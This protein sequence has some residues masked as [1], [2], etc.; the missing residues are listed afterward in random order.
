MRSSPQR[1]RSAAE[2]GGLG[3]Q[4]AACPHP[5]HRRDAVSLSG[6]AQRHRLV[7]RR[8]S[9][10]VSRV[11]C[12]TLFLHVWVG[13]PPSQISKLGLFSVIIHLIMDH[14]SIWSNM[15]AISTLP[16][17]ECC[18]PSGLGLGEQKLRLVFSFLGSAQSSKWGGPGVAMSPAF[19]NSFDPQ[20]ALA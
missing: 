3:D 4:L 19:S 16:R 11:H 6:R 1:R 2:G 10:R 14:S 17:E 8:G 15:T 5:G 13:S 9:R 18:W 12:L 20:S 7:R